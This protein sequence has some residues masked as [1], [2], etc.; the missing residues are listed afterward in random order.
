MNVTLH[1]LDGKHDLARILQV[2]ELA[3]VEL[4]GARPGAEVTL[5]G[6]PFRCDRRGSLRLRLD[7]DFHGRIGRYAIKVDG[8]ELTKIDIWPQKI[9]REGFDRLV[10]ELQRTWLH[11][12]VDD[13]GPRPGGASAE[14][15][16]R[17]LRPLVGRIL[18]E[19]RTRLERRPVVIRPELAR[20]LPPTPAVR[21]A[22]A[23]QRPVVV[24]GL[25]SV[26]AA[27]DHALVADTL[28]RLATLARR[29]AV[30]RIG[31]EVG[32]LLRLPLLRDVSHRSGELRLG[33]GA[34]HDPRYREIARI[35]RQ[36][37]EERAP[38]VE[39]PTEARYG[40]HAVDRLYEYWVFLRIVRWMG[41]HRGPTETDLRSLA[42]PLPGGRLRLELAP[43]TTVRFR[44]GIEVVFAPRIDDGSDSWRGLRP[45]GPNERTPD[46]V[47]WQ[48][49]EVR[50][51]RVID[52]K[53]RAPERILDATRQ[54]HERYGRIADADGGVVADVVAAHPN[55]GSTFAYA[56]H[57]AVSFVPGGT[58]DV[59][60]ALG[61]PVG[62][63][64]GPSPQAPLRRSVPS[65]T[66]FAAPS[67]P[68]RTG[69]R[70]AP[71]AT[72]PG[73]VDLVYDQRWAREHLGDRRLDLG[74]LREWLAAG[75]PIRRQ[76]MLAPAIAPLDGFLGVASGWGWELLPC[77]ADRPS[78]LRALDEVVAG[79]GP[80]VLVSGMADALALVDAVD[81]EIVDD[82]R[83]A[84]LRW[85][86][87][88]SHTAQ[89]HIGI[90]TPGGRNHERP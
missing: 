50:P 34:R 28:R 7:R 88:G 79:G 23:R 17:Q 77:G 12:V 47:V 24:P 13:Q 10:E 5:G 44:D 49:G 9:S 52:A 42:R 8:V 90:R 16:W 1:T 71:H 2:G 63:P 38:L 57:R 76:A 46:V 33:Q 15:L 32:E 81:H 84:P 41:K 36:L 74:A 78:Q 45:G 21:V 26:P 65:T 85:L 58:V 56:G 40:L 54:I 60:G 3:V 87:A 43:G 27:L 69:R 4:L 31:A 73:P 53:Y 22:A 35:R 64:R 75:R 66:A 89:H 6:R 86:R 61:E 72:L 59:E 25:V 20:R 29:N 51:L 37:L 70:R 19:P 18:D 14:V 11:L 39:G 48:P 80:V 67:A 83:G 68:A 82:L 55:E 30:D 62:R